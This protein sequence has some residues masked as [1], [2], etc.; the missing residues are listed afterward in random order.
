[1]SQ[2]SGSIEPSAFR[3]PSRLDF[4][5]V[6]LPARTGKRPR[7]Q[8]KRWVR[9]CR[10]PSCLQSTGDIFATC[11]KI[12]QCGTA[13]R[14]PKPLNSPSRA[15]LKFSECVQAS[16]AGASLASGGSP[17]RKKDGPAQGR[18]IFMKSLQSENDAALEPGMPAETATAHHGRRDHDRGDH[19]DRRCRGGNDDGRSRGHR[20][21]RRRDDHR[22]CGRRDYDRGAVR[23][24][25]AERAT[26][27]T[28]SASACGL[29]ANGGERRQQHG[30]GN[31][32]IKC[33]E[34]WLVSPL[35][36]R[37]KNSPPNVPETTA[38][39]EMPPQS[40]SAGIDAALRLGAPPKAP[41]GSNKNMFKI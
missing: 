35:V 16:E 4:E 8:Q 25:D 40:Q 21:N 39:G 29:R 12:C 5:S 18:P 22:R 36:P 37:K 14:P 27:E 31:G 11:R 28:G 7:D 15:R 24:A 34:H 26:V 9:P 38:N 23:H 2:T 19:R 41:N 32:A 13:T 20:H 30:T 17:H 10:F 6:A 33:P 1:M 3:R